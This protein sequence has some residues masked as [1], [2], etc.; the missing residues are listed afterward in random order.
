MNIQVHYKNVAMS[1]ALNNFV[2]LELESLFEKFQIMNAS[3]DIYIESS[4]ARTPLRNP[5]FSCEFIYKTDYHRS[6]HKV[7]REGRDLF[8]ILN[9]SIYIIEQG[10]SERSSRKS[11]HRRYQRRDLKKDVFKMIQ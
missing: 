1:E 8:T 3:A 6:S 10:L 2:R 11:D 9:E 5:I 4:R 7:R